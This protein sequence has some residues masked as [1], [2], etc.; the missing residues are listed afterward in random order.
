VCSIDITGVDRMGDDATS[1]VRWCQPRLASAG[2]DG[3]G[4]PIFDAVAI[5]SAS[6]SVSL[7]GVSF[8]SV[9]PKV[10]PRADKQDR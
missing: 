4:A 10:P 2:G 8:G 3:G 1:A 9:D 5:P 6:G 7:C